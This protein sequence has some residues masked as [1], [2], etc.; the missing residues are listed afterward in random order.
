MKIWKHFFCGIILLLIVVL[1][2]IANSDIYRKINICEISTMVKNSNTSI[3]TKGKSAVAKVGQSKAIGKNDSGINTPIISSIINPEINT[4]INN[5]ASQ[6]S[7]E[8]SDFSNFRGCKW[9]LIKDL[10]NNHIEDKCRVKPKWANKEK[11]ATMWQNWIDKTAPSGYQPMDTNNWSDY[12]EGTCS[13]SSSSRSVPQLSID[14]VNNSSVKKINPKINGSKAITSYYEIIGDSS[15][16]IFDS[17]ASPINTTNES[18]TN[19]EVMSCDHPEINTHM[20]HDSL[21]NDNIFDNENNS[22]NESFQMVGESGINTLLNNYHQC[23]T[24]VINGTGI[25][26]L[27]NDYNNYISPLFL[28]GPGINTLPDEYVDYNTNIIDRPGIN[29]LPK[30]YSGIDHQNN[31]SGI[32]TLP[33]IVD[34]GEVVLIENSRNIFNSP[35]INTHT[36]IN[37]DERNDIVNANTFMIVDINNKVIHDNKTSTMEVDIHKNIRDEAS[38]E[39]EVEEQLKR[40]KRDNSIQENE[41]AK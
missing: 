5:S 37:K 36:I 23:A 13:S 16:E 33:M 4:L 6:L 22:N 15:N 14:K 20:I 11:M 35:A 1:I 17:N 39:E 40:V 7:D 32:N 27:P 24:S 8:K 18:D 29:T 2:L 21:N 3:D 26:T 31:R 28:K 9:C 34:E 38:D 19:I 12:A 10:E 30:D 41:K 25:N